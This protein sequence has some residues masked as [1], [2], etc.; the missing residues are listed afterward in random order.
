MKAATEANVEK[1][2]FVDIQHWLGHKDPR[3]TLRYIRGME[4]VD[5]SPGIF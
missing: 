4:D 3:T 5:N 2:P 1:V